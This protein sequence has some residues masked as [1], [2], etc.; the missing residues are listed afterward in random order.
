MLKDMKKLLEKHEEDILF[1]EKQ[2][3]RFEALTEKRME[4]V[5]TIMHR[6][7]GSIRELA[8]FLHRDVKNV[9]DDLKVLNQLGVV[10]FVRIGRRKR[11]VVKRRIIVISFE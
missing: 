3:Q 6:H 2:L 9:F 11:P 8:D 4:M 7:P 1:M 10:K 5:R